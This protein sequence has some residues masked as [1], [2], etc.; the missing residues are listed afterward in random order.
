MQLP[1]GNRCFEID[2][3]HSDRKDLSIT[4][5]PDL[6]ITASA[7][8]STP[9][10]QVEQRLKRRAHWIGKQVRYFEQ[11]LPQSPPRRYLSGETH[12]YLGRQYRLKIE[13]TE[14]S[15]VRLSRGYFIVKVPDPHDC[16][17]VKKILALWYLEHFKGLIE[18][19]VTLYW[20]RFEKLGAQKPEFRYR[21]MTRSWGS[22]SVQ[23]TISLNLELSKVS[24]ECIDYVLIHELC[25]LL[26]SHHDDKF[27]RLLN[28][29]MPDWKTRKEKLERKVNAPALEGRGLQKPS[30]TRRHFNNADV[31]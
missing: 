29:M 17:Q 30:L 26:C 1:Y 14:L 27:F 23:G 19:R 28:R 16:E 25:H 12:Y 5:H 18:K 9:F 6:R 2:I 21:Q 8:L 3:Q 31:G 15:S 24:L 10:E 13:T 11:F 22:C 7:P 4:V 20:S